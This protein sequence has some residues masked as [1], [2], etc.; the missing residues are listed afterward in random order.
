MESPLLRVADYQ[1][2]VFFTGAGVSAESGVPTYRGRGGIWKHYDYERY[3]SQPAF[4]RNPEEVWRFHNVRRERVAKCLPNAAHRCIAACEAHAEHVSVITQNIDGLH[5]RAG[6]NVVHELH[7]SLWR[8]RCD[9]CGYTATEFDAPLRDVR[10]PHCPAYKRP[11]I[12]WFGDA[13]DPAVFEIATQALIRCDLLVSIGTSAL[14]YPAA[15][16]PMLARRH[17]ARLVEINPEPTPMSPQFDTCLRTTAS[18]GLDR[19]LGA[20]DPS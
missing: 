13:L 7:G 15:E 12:V 4:E 19:L 11:D 6:S 17:G 5:Q 14:V 1:H 10:C 16:L 3:A 9:D 8:S 2:V 18:A 20:F